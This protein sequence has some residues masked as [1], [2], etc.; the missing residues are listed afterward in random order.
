MSRRHCPICPGQSHP[1]LSHSCAGKLDGSFEDATY[2]KGRSS[3]LGNLYSCSITVFG[4]SF[5]SSEQ[6]YQY[7]K[8]L[9]FH[10]P[11]D[12]LSSVKLRA[13]VY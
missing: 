8:A 1:P 11:G 6:A 12:T 13:R 3:V 5:S 7:K 4:V 10:R 9:H 2:F